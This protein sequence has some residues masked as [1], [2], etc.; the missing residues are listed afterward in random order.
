MN[1]IPGLTLHLKAALFFQ[2]QALHHSLPQPRIPV[3]FPNI[4]SGVKSYLMLKL[5]VI[6]SLPKEANKIRLTR[7]PCLWYK[8]CRIKG[9]SQNLKKYYFRPC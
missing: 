7:L 4:G 2:N 5:K 8:K 1:N 9:I 3:E 6:W